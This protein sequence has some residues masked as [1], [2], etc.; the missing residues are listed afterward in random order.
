MIPNLEHRAPAI[1]PVAERRLREA[2]RREPLLNEWRI[3][4]VHPVSRG[5]YTSTGMRLVHE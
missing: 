4:D 5:F 3:E 2:I 1:E